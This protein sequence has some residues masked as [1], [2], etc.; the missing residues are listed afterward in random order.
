MLDVISGKTG[1]SAD[2]SMIAYVLG[3]IKA[4]I[5]TNAVNNMQID[6]VINIS[7]VALLNLN[8]IVKPFQS[9][10]YPKIMHNLLSIINEV[11]E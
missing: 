10:Q 2:F 4:S 5:K 8:F 11:N 7:L 9:S 1:S 3:I 6:P